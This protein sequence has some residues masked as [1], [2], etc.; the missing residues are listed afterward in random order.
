[1]KLIEKFG[2]DQN[3]L[4]AAERERKRKI[5]RKRECEQVL[6]VWSGGI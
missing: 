6:M 4:A 1:M 5:V 3:R 2:V